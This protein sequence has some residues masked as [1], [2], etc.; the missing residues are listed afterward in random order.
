MSQ[1]TTEREDAVREIL[2]NAV[3]VQLAAFKAGIAF[4]KDWIEQTSK[5]VGTA[6]DQLQS[7]RSG[8]REAKQLL[9]EVVDAGRESIRAMTELPR[10]AAFRFIEELDELE[11]RKRPTPGATNARPKADARPRE[12]KGK[13]ARKRRPTRAARIKS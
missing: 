1:A 13:A 10:Q 5:F 11:V 6:T 7:I 3:E 4:W 9:L 8:D 12:P 2:T